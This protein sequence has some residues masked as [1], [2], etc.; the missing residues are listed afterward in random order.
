MENAAKVRLTPEVESIRPALVRCIKIAPKQT[1]TFTLLA[2]DRAAKA[3]SQSVTVRVTDPLPR[4]TD[5]SI[6]AKE[7]PAGEVVAFCFKATDAV[8]VRGKPGY[9]F[10]GGSPQGDCLVHQPQRTTSYQITIEGAGKRTDDAT[11]TV[12]V[13]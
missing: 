12:R 6:S 13:R 3:I 1:T 10:R 5:L 7:V 2:A 8:A 4:F 9:F 11:I